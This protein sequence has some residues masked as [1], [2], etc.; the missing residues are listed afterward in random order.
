VGERREDECP[1]FKMF[2]VKRWSWTTKGEK[3]RQQRKEEEE[4][5]REASRLTPTERTTEEMK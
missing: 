4:N 5:R 2:I 1:R 3:R